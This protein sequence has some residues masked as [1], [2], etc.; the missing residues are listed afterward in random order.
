VKRV[1]EL[2]ATP[3]PNVA[4]ATHGQRARVAAAP[5]NAPPAVGVSGLAQLAPAE[6]A[7]ML[8]Q[9]AARTGVVA[10]RRAANAIYQQNSGRPTID[11]RAALDEAIWLFESGTVRTLNA[12]FKMAARSIAGHRTVRAVAER[13]RKKHA[14]MKKSPAK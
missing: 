1:I 3:P 10:F 4:R 14:A 2:A 5:A 11:D 12:G 8:E 7:Q 9:V 13:L 6:L